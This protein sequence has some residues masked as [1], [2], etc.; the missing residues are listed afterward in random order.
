MWVVK[1]SVTKWLTYSGHLLSPSALFS[2][3]LHAAPQESSLVFLCTAHLGAPS[4]G[5]KRNPC[6]SEDSGTHPRPL[7]LGIPGCSV[8]DCCPKRRA[9]VLGRW[10]CCGDQPL[11]KEAKPALCCEEEGQEESHCTAGFR[12]TNT[13]GAHGKSNDPALGNRRA[14]SRLPRFMDV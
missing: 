1:S 13:V 11:W 8:S 14:P 12:S 7:Y 6:S 10:L 5:Q 2:S 9:K 3:H 4:T